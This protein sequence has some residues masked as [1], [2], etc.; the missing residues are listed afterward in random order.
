MV[1]SVHPP[2]VDGAV[3]EKVT[4]GRAGRRWDRVVWKVWKDTR[5]KQEDIKSAEEFGRYKAELEKIIESRERLG[6]KKQGEIG[7]TLGD[8]RGI[9][10]RDR[11]ENVFAR[12]NGLREK[13]E[14]A[15][16]CR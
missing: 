1:S 2:I 14:N 12:P 10:Q 13:D 15:I 5:G 16:S 8:I 6:A 7:E 3:W 11:N 4:K 9:K